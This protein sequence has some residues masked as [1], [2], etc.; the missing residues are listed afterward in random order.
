MAGDVPSWSV[1]SI[2]ISVKDLDRST[3][4]YQ[5]VMHLRE[6]AREG[7]MAV[8]SEDATGLF[9]LYLRQAQRNAVRSGQQSLGVRSVSFNVG[10]LAELDRVEERLRAL[11]AFRQ[12]QTVDEAGRFDV[13]FGYDPDRLALTFS[14]HESG[15]TMHVSHH[16]AVGLLYAVDL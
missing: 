5:D 16:R 12:R 15:T 6:V 1:R 8:L 2:V 3:T 10:S 7:D 13:V 14:A 4:F 9:P 11:D